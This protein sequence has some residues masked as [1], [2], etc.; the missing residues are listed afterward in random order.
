MCPTKRVL[1]TSLHSPARQY[2][3]HALPLEFQ[4][5]ATLRICSVGTTGYGTVASLLR[6]A[7]GPHAR[8]TPAPEHFGS[9]CKH[10]GMP[11]SHRT[12]ACAFLGA[13]LGALRESQAVCSGPT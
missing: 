4:P 12:L 9:S 6:C 8:C 1:P 2:L 11:H 3:L 10:C 13:E 5:R 7:D